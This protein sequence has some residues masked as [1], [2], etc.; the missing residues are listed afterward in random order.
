LAAS[1][2]SHFTAPE[3][4]RCLAFPVLSKVD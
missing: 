2:A 3:S 1:N 4:C